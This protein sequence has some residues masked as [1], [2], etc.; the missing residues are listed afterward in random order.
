MKILF[1]HG[2]CQNAQIFCKKTSA[3]RKQLEP[4]YECIYISAPNVPTARKNNEIEER[5]WW[6][7]FEQQDK[8]IYEGLDK[9]VASLKHEWMKGG[10]VGVIGFSQGATSNNTP[11]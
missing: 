7:A 1:L 9:S 11:P 4:L 6:N 10:F 3:L 8:M 2:Y 5:C